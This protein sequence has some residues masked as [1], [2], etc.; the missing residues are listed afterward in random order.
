M[1]G[2]LHLYSKESRH[3]GCNQ[4]CSV[5]RLQETRRENL[6]SVLSD[7]G[8]SLR[9]LLLQECAAIEG[10]CSSEV[11]SW[12]GRQRPIGHRDGVAGGRI[13]RPLINGA[14]VADGLQ[15][16]TALL[17][18]SSHRSSIQLV[19]PD[20]VRVGLLDGYEYKAIREG[21]VEVMSGLGM[22]GEGGAGAGEGVG[23]CVL[24][25]L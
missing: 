25:G 12:G 18:T 4:G 24:T 19:H 11:N 7:F 13:T 3:Y 20:G 2:E 22:V 8:C 17:S 1:L 14:A 23:R 21:A 6:G 9:P 15:A 16:D 5:R 10:K